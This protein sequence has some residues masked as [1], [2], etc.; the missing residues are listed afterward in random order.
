MGGIKGRGL[1]QLTTGADDVSSLATRARCRLPLG[2]SFCSHWCMMM[3]SSGQGGVLQP[4]L[5]MTSSRQG[6]YFTLRAVDQERA[7]KLH[8]HTDTHR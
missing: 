5:M 1:L 2:T 6:G 8:A 4:D 7:E 3:T